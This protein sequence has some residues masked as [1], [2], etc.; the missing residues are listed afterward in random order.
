MGFG[1]SEN[2]KLYCRICVYVACMVLLTGNRLAAHIKSI[3]IIICIHGIDWVKRTALPLNTLL[4]VVQIHANDIW[5][6]ADARI[7]SDCKISPIKFRGALLVFMQFQCSL[8][9]LKKRLEMRDFV[10]WRRTKRPKKRISIYFFYV[11]LIHALTEVTA[12][13]IY[14][15]ATHTQKPWKNGEKRKMLEMHGDNWVRSRRADEAAT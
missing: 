12:F 4:L 1:M 3:I 15:S 2:R 7:Y 11:W 13:R 6:Y 5:K 14:I 9:E 10:R 8:L